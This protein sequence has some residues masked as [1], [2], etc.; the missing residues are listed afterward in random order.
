MV[1]NPILIRDERAED[2]DVITAVTVAAF[3]TLAI[4]NHTEQMIVEALRASGALTVSLVAE[5]DGCVVGH[6][7][8]SPVT[9]SD[10]TDGWYGLGPVSVL[11]T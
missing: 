6:I 11:P 10:G 4:S 8:F 7:A 1:N 9:M 5:L 2:A 3:E